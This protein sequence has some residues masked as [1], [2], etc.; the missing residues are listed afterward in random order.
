MFPESLDIS[1]S[2]PGRNGFDYSNFTYDLETH[3]GNLTHLAVPSM[4]PTQQRQGGADKQAR[5]PR[6]DVRRRH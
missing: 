3:I 5:R 1:N 6:L 2:S 4:S